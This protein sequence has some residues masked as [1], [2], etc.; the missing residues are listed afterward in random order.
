MAALGL[1]HVVDRSIVYPAHHL[2][3]GVD[4]AHPQRVVLVPPAQHRARSGDGDHRVIMATPLNHS[5]RAEPSGVILTAL[6][7]TSKPRIKSLSGARSREFTGVH[8]TAQIARAY[9][10]ELHRRG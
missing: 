3:V 8:A 4:G 7:R 9:F 5:R 6:I 10:N 1:L 2:W